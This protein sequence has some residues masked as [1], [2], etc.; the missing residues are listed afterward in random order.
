MFHSSCS[1]LQHKQA[2]HPNPVETGLKK[3]TLVRTWHSSGPNTGAGPRLDLVL[4]C[5]SWKPGWGLKGG[6][7]ALRDTGP[8]AHQQCVKHGRLSDLVTPVTPSLT[9][10]MPGRGG[11]KR[12]ERE[13]ILWEIEWEVWYSEI[14]RIK[15]REVCYSERMREWK[16]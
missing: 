3:Y 16:R 14:S 13:V 7:L 15:E 6:L 9:P 8:D 11:G 1:I 2:E 5:G 4:R 10:L 12:R